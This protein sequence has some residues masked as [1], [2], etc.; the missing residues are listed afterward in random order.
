MCQ[1]LLA[2]TTTCSGVKRCPPDKGYFAGQAVAGREYDV[3][4]GRDTQSRALKAPERA[5]QDVG[6]AASHSSC[7]QVEGWPVMGARK[8]L[9]AVAGVASERVLPL[10]ALCGGACALQWKRRLPSFL[11]LAHIF[12]CAP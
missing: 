1:G 11:S 8:R 7:Q 4:Q 3:R 12:A 9:W 6:R 10:C 2:W 5:V